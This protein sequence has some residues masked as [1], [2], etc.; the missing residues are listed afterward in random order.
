MATEAIEPLLHPTPEERAARGKAAREACS[1][2]RHA[3]FEPTGRDPVS[4]LEAQAATRI[5]ELVPIRYGRMLVSPFAFHR[6][7]SAVMAYDLAPLPRSGLDAQLCGDAHLGNFGGFGSAERDLVFDLN[8]FDETLPGPFEWDVKR[9]AASIA[10]AGRTRMLGES[11]CRTA[12]VAMVASYREAMRQFAQMGN[13]EVWYA[14]VSVD[15][16]VTRLS[17]ERQEAEASSLARAGEKARSR[18]H[19][20]A[21]R[22]L[23]TTVDGQPRIRYDPPLVIPVGELF[24]GTVARDEI[25]T[26]VRSILAGFRSTLQADRRELLDSYEVVDVAHKVVGVSSVG[27][28][29]WIVLMIGRDTS[30]PLFV[31]V[32]EAQAS[33]LEPYLGASG[34]AT[35]GQRVVSGQR[36]MQATGD[37]F[38]GWHRATELDNTERDYFCRQLWDWKGSANLDTLDAGTLGP[39]GRLCGWTLARAHA[40]S[41][42]R[43]AIAEY[44]G[45]GDTFD[46]A[47]MTFAS[48]YADQN[49]R[50][51]SAFEQAARNGRIEVVEGV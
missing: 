17:E 12:V 49:E 35:H 1:R 39:Y 24:G 28:R 19:L 4:L 33:V 34:F 11:A 30:D 5:P 13:L 15:G 41:G 46:E 27:T 29:C 42:D 23:T 32:K 44:L 8:D 20:K 36:L 14:R 18:D 43:I 22:K 51:Y 6:G 45:K 9:L 31:Q 47:I 50:D 37:L 2:R 10:I 21:F 38:L 48:V 40:R 16:L 26:L 3:N 25:E 7:T